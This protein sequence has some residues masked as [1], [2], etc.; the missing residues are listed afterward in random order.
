[1]KTNKKIIVLAAG[2]I[3]SGAFG[4]KAMGQ[5]DSSGILTE[6]NNIKSLVEDRDIY[7]E[8]GNKE[9]KS[10]NPFD[11]G[12]LNFAPVTQEPAAQSPAV[13]FIL[14][15]VFLG[16]A[17]PSVI[18]NGQVAGVGNKIEDATVKEIKDG[19]V[20]LEEGNKEIVLSLKR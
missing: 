7:H 14:Q 8:T 1:M 6:Q 19:R 12:R 4:L 9:W 16:T 11:T 2:L 17:K 3:L 20:V 15:G 10:R 13:V 5:L 18:I